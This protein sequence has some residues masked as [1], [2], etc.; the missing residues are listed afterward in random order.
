M[1]N[2]LLLIGL[3][4]FNSHAQIGIGTSTPQ[5]ELHLAGSTST[6]RIEK[7]NSVNNPV[8]NDGVKLAPVFVDQDGELTLNP[9][10]YITDVGSPTGVAPLNF[11]ITLGNFIPDNGGVGVALNNPIGVTNA[12]GQIAIVPFVSPQNALI[13]VKY[14]VT[15][16]LSQGDLTVPT[17]T[18]FTDKSART[19]HVYF[20]I[21]LNSDGLDASELSKKYGDKGQFY[22][23]TAQGILG[24]PY[25][26]SHGYANIPAGN[27]R[28]I[29]FGE[30]IDGINK[31][32][33]VGFGGDLDYMK[34]RL[35]N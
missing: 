10:N 25:M 3:I 26:N 9:P 35:Y 23:S 13:E 18:A 28:L 14:G 7:L 33:S 22:A 31:F 21:D 17:Y 11:L 12:S 15:I 34:I 2:I 32:T 5:K 29:F 6:I 30:S 27:H 24:Y 8:L 20:C 19:F 4:T 1:K 16:V